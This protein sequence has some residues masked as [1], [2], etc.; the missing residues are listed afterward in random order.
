[1][2]S[3]HHNY[4]AWFWVLICTIIVMVHDCI[5][6]ILTNVLQYFSVSCIMY[7]TDRRNVIYL[8]YNH[9]M[10]RI[11]YTILII[12]KYSLEFH[13]GYMQKGI[14]EA[15]LINQLN[16]AWL[17]WYLL[18]LYVAYNKVYRGLD[19]SAINIVH[20]L[21]YILYTCTIYQKPYNASCWP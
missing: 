20:V 6:C 14:I 16:I 7:S 3:V 11:Y 5:A 4:R 8:S 21:L 1:M 19:C 17:V 2:H 9:V 18:Y 12:N 10:W 13:E 15:W